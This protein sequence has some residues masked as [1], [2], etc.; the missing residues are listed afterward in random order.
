MAE[1]NLSDLKRLVKELETARNARAQAQRLVDAL[2]KPPE[3]TTV[4]LMLTVKNEDRHAREEAINFHVPLTQAD[5]YQSKPR[6]VEANRQM[7][8][9]ARRHAH[10]RLIGWASK[11]EG[12][13]FQIRRLTK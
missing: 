12:L 1:L 3:F 5:F 13:E 9:A 8:L 4:S 2:T 6:A 10:E 11:V 7:L